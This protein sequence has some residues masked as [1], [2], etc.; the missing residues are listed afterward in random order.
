MK[1]KRSPLLIAVITLP[2]IS[3][4]LGALNFETNRAILQNEWVSLWT[5]FSLFMCY[6]FFPALIGAIASY[7]WRLERRANGEAE[8]F[9]LPRPL[10]TIVLSKLFVCAVLVMAS[11]LTLFICYF[12]IGSFMGF[13]TSFPLQTCILYFVLGTL[14][15]LPVIIF[16]LLLSYKIQNF[17]IPVGIGFL[18]GIV[19]LIAASTGIGSVYLYSLIQMGM[20]S[21]S[22][23]DLSGSRI[24][25][26]VAVCLLYLGI[27]YP[28]MLMIMR[29]R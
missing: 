2:I 29:K 25:Q 26:L 13:S 28:G 24:I 12:I 1:L 20:N 3:S 21:N 11:L 23:V 6:M 27:L 15:S 10:W 4:V 8:L 14:G 16:Q 5:Q 22:L 17:A 19:G 9:C 7:L 18:G